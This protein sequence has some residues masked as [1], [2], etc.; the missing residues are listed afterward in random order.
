VKVVVWKSR[1]FWF[2]RCFCPKSFASFSALSFAARR[3]QDPNKTIKTYRFVFFTGLCGVSLHLGHQNLKPYYS[4][5]LAQVSH[6]KWER[7][8]KTVLMTQALPFGTSSPWSLGNLPN[9]YQ[10]TMKW[11]QYTRATAHH[12]RLIVQCYNYVSYI[13]TI[14]STSEAT[15]WL[16]CVKTQLKFSSH[17]LVTSKAMCLSSLPSTLNAGEVSGQLHVFTF[18]LLEKEPQVLTDG[19]PVFDCKFWRRVKYLP[20]NLPMPPRNAQPKENTKYVPKTKGIWPPLSPNLN[21]C[22]FRELRSSGLLRSE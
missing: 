22:E 5:L 17:L 8:V 4:R 21:P 19:G 2:K 20:Q 3:R 1:S 16:H 9:N 13:C 12:C 6:K 10:Q 18:L 15:D 14:K 11:M 7:V